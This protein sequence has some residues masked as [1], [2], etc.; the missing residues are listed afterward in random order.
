MKLLLMLALIAATISSPSRAGEISSLAE[1]KTPVEIKGFFVRGTRAEIEV[2]VQG[3]TTQ[4]QV[5]ILTRHYGRQGLIV[6]ANEEGEP[7]LPRTSEPLPPPDT[8]GM[9][10]RQ[11][12]SRWKTDFV[13][14]PEFGRLQEVFAIVCAVRE[15]QNWSKSRDYRGFQYLPF[16]RATDINDALDLLRDFGWMPTGLTRIAP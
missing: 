15:R 4:S 8:I 12:L 5:V 14:K 3:A 10:S 1:V 2:V 7:V 16:N 9:P 11:S 6:A 13:V